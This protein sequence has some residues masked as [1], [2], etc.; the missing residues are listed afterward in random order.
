M[1]V[2]VDIN[3]SSIKR[4]L[5]DCPDQRL[6]QNL[7]NIQTVVLF[8][9]LGFKFGPMELFYLGP[10]T[11]PIINKAQ[12]R[13]QPR[14]QSRNPKRSAASWNFIR[15]GCPQSEERRSSREINK[16]KRE[17]EEKKKRKSIGRKRAIGEGERSGVD[18]T[19]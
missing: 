7:H 15:G 4:N 12:S 19:V 2:K 16:T 11:K 9:R 18:Q 13:I 17:K 5:I 1:R 10:W 3:C 14:K 8:Q 6:Q